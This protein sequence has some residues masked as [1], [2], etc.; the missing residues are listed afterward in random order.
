MTPANAPIALG[1]QQQY[2]ALATLSDSTTQDVTNVVTWASSDPSSISITTSGL[3]TGVKVMSTPVTISATSSNNVVGST[4]ATVNAG[5]LVSIAV[6]PT[7]V[8]TLAQGTSQQFSAIGTFNNGSTLDLTNQ[9]QWAIAP[10]GLATVAQK[11]GLVTANPS[12]Q[13]NTLVTL[14]ASLGNIQGSQQFTVTNAT[15]VPP[16]TVT[17]ITATVQPGATQIF[18][19]T[20]VFNDGSSQ[21]V[22]LNST[23][24]SSNPAQAKV[25]F[26][27]RL[28][29]VSTT[30]SGSPVT[31]TA[32]FGTPPVSG[33]A[34]LAVSSA[35]LQTITLSP[36]NANLTPGSTVTFQAN[37]NYSD[38]STANLSGLVTWAPA[39]PNPVVTVSNGTALGQGPGNANVTA[40]YQGVTGTAPVVVTSSP[41]TKITVTTPGN[42]STYV[43][44]L[45]PLIATGT[46][47]NQQ[48]GLTTSAT[49]ASLNSAVAT[50]SNAAGRQG[51]T[52][53]VG[54]G[55]T[56]INAVFAGITGSLN[57]TVSSAVLQSIAVTPAS[58]TIN[59]GN[60]QPYTAIGT[61]SD[62][63][64]F[65]LTNQV[66]WIS[67]SPAV[68]PISSG[69]L[70]SGATPGI[71]HITATFTQPG[72]AQ[73]TS[74]QATLTVQ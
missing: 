4:T 58:A 25:A 45:I 48:I 68:A 65:D 47:G 31:V 19:A 64:T 7:N 41:V 66:T 53:G 29:G 38:G 15:P 74:N 30:P 59:A 39:P 9:V 57:V 18:H 32:T 43:G 60:S 52:T 3:A 73:V 55:S 63:T 20:A 6:K 50:V 51:F 44:V 14:T 5:N 12:V 72:Q 37:G 21:D 70:A 69:G 36:P 61:F 71:T 8:A 22:S 28:L 11:T 2:D 33:T 35:A 42:P 67:S 17:P 23:W 27:G 24:T 49:W 13:T 1:L 26:P 16:L 10:Q 40:K 54:A 56:T 34:S 62:S 46:A